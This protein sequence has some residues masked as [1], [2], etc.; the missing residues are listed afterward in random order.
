ME[1]IKERV[2]GKEKDKW[3]KILVFPEGTTTSGQALI[4]FKDGAFKPG[5]PVQPVVFRFNS[6]PSHIHPGWVTAGP[7]PGAILL[8]LF[9][10]PFNNVQVEWLP[11]YHP[12]VDEQKDPTLYGL[13]VRKEM[14]RV[15]GIPV[16]EHSYEDT[17]LAEQAYTLT[18]SIEP[19]VQLALSQ[20]RDQFKLDHHSVLAQFQKFES[21]DKQHSGQL[22]YED[23]CSAL[24]V[25]DS[26]TMRHL[27]SLSLM[28]MRME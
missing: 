25:S 19:T 26:P 7:K 22:T 11:I 23:L 13:G 10:E 12:N 6:A 8:R 20:L 5:I 24:N 15:L 4:T 14:A 16:T 27:F 18:R 28:K 9:C 3:S 17:I 2:L 21:F 1:K